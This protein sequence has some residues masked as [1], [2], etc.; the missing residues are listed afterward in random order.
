MA[1]ETD[2][3]DL[4]GKLRLEP[5]CSLEEFKQA[6]R[7]NVA[8]WHPDRRRGSRADV[9]AAARLQ[10]LTAQYGAAMDFYRRHGRL[11]GAP[12]PMRA[13]DT[14]VAVADAA[15]IDPPPEPR[16]VTASVPPSTDAP[17]GLPLRWWFGAALLGIG[18]VVWWMWPDGYVAESGD[19]RRVPAA[20]HPGHAPV[21]TIAPGMTTDEVIAI[22]GEPTRRADDRWEYG[23]SWVRFEDD[24]VV[25][26]YSSPLRA[27]HVVSP[28]PRR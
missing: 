5:G 17:R 12:R 25:D 21:V 2:F 27:L 15:D 16:P 8:L 18:A 22:E 19:E 24:Q 20:V 3:L 23:P 9:L 13:V 11:P 14:A 7:R 28:R 26:W 10:R 6:Y 1:H 4:Y